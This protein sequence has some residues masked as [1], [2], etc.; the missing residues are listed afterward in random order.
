MTIK[1]FAW[2]YTSAAGAFALHRDATS[3][4]F[5][6]DMKAATEHPLRHWMLPL[7]EQSAL[8]AAVAA[9][10]ERFAQQL[11]RLG[12]DHCAAALRNEAQP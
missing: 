12:C 7:Y 2:L 8:D 5:E 4:R 10:R 1:P 6:A 9:E 3:L 11:E